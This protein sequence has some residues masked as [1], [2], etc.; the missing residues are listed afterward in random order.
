MGEAY[1]YRVNPITDVFVETLLTFDEDI[2]KRD[3]KEEIRIMLIKFLMQFIDQ[4]ELELFEFDIKNS[5]TGIKIIAKNFATALVFCNII[6]NNF[7]VINSQETLQLNEFIYS[8]DKRK[9][10]LIK[11]KNNG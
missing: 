7:N 1:K 2:S 4:K 8:F 11:V 9:K 5:K 10:S 6:P 3:A